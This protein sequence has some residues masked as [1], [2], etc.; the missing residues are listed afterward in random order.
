MRTTWTALLVLASGFAALGLRGQSTPNPVSPEVHPDRRV[1]FRIR[2][3]EATKVAVVDGGLIEALG[4][5]QEMTKGDDGVWSITVGP[6]E[7]GI[8]DYGFSIGDSARVA[9]PGNRNLIRRTWGPTSFVEVPGDEPQVYTIRDVPHGAVTTHT[10][11]SKLLNVVRQFL[12]YTP[13]GYQRSN[14]TYP[15]LYLYHGGGGDETQ[16]FGWRL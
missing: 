8:Y 9:D 11:N 2:A 16:W 10:Y 3:P 4:G 1:T 15:V 14:A 12:V 7:P 6:L 5:P 13:P